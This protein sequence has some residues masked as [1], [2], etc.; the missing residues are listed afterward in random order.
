MN[1]ILKCNEPYK[2]GVCV[3]VRIVNRLQFFWENT[4]SA[5]DAV[6]Q[7]KLFLLGADKASK[8]DAA[9]TLHRFQCSVV[10]KIGKLDLEMDI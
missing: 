5:L 4:Y 1:W 7:G 2:N 6:D 8:S 10:T 9:N 3:S